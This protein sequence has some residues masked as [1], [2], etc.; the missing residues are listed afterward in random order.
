M[1]NDI[2][3]AGYWYTNNSEAVGLY[4]WDSRVGFYLRNF[5]TGTSDYYNGLAIP[6]YITI[7]RT[8]ATAIECRVYSDA[9]RT[10]LLD[11]I[12]IALNSKSYR[13]I[14]PFN[15]WATGYGR[16]TLTVEDLDLNEYPDSSAIARWAFYGA[17]R[18]AELMFANGLICTQLNNARTHSAV[19]SDLANPAWGDQSSDRLGYDGAGR[20]ITKR[21][22]SAAASDSGYS[23]TQA[24]VGFTTAYDHASNKQYERELHAESRSHVYPALDS[25]DRLLQYQRGTLQ[26]AADGTVA[27][28]TYESAFP[29]LLTAYGQ[30]DSGPLIDMASL[31]ISSAVMHTRDVWHTI[32][33]QTYMT[34]R[35]WSLQPLL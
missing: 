24:K 31:T 7:E 1:S 14:F 16:S 2:H 4:I 19:Q 21:Y 26:Q 5:E 27:E 11:T 18:V 22:L 35:Q 23:S 34:D 6:N 29:R 12:S 9:L 13:Y 30:P 25:M 3:E 32:L 15:S 28:R 8:A 17:G 20:M 33:V 10:I